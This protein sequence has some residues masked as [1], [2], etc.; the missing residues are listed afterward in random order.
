MLQFEFTASRKKEIMMKSGVIPKMLVGMVIV[1]LAGVVLLEAEEL[2]F[3]IAARPI[4]RSAP[5]VFFCFSN[6]DPEP[7]FGG[8][9]CFETKTPNPRCAKNHR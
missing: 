6:L 2:S 3:P 1:F 8:F 5:S 7:F 4:G 9:F